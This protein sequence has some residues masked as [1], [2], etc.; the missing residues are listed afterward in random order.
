VKKDA[1]VLPLPSQ[2]APTIGGNSRRQSRNRKL[3]LAVESIFAHSANKDHAAGA[4]RQERLI[5]VGVE[6]EAWFAAGDLQEVDERRAAP[7][8]QIT[9]FNNVFAVGRRRPIV[10]P[11]IGVSAFADLKIVVHLQLLPVFI[12]EPQVRIERRLLPPG[13]HF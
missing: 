6:F 13:D 2:N 12:E 9:Q 8:V 10:D 7:Q 3:H 4:G 1:A 5:G 11:R